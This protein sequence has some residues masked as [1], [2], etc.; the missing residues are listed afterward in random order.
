M[1]KTY[2]SLLLLCSYS[3]VS[4]MEN[5]VELPSKKEINSRLNSLNLKH[6]AENT[7][8]SEDLAWEKKHPIGVVVAI[9]SALKSYRPQNKQLAIQAKTSRQD[10]IKA[11]LKNDPE[12]LECLKEYGALHASV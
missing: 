4:P 2:L 9:D 5:F 12:A 11:I 7:Q 1:T 10:I 8:I 3:T 6:F